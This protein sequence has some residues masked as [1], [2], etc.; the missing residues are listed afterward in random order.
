[1]T[2]VRRRQ[3][4]GRIACMMRPFATRVAR[5]V[6]CMPVT[7]CFGIPVNDAKTTE[8]IEMPFGG[9]L[10]GPRNHRRGSRSPTEKTFKG[11]CARHYSG[12]L[13][14]RWMQQMVTLLS[15]VDIRSIS[16]FKYQPFC[17]FLITKLYA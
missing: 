12:G 11:A 13:C 5:S 8:S 7:L 2:E 16:Y 3:L 14:A 15:P 10:V 9:R 4:L 6:V 17:N 1:M